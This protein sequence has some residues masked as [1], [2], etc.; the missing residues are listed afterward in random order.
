[1]LA[2]SVRYAAIDGR[3]EDL[4][5]NTDAALVPLV[6]ENWKKIFTW[7]WQGTMP[8]SERAALKE[9]VIPRA[10]AGAQSS[11]L[12][13]TRPRGSVED[14]PRCRVSMYWGQTIWRAATL[15]AR[16]DTLN[17]RASMVSAR[18]AGICAR[19]CVRITR[20]PRL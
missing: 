16:I 8:D 4:E 20:K 1:M 3:K 9:W 14:S 18:Q 6:S 2:Q 13:Y 15:P 10:C 11:I 5:R 17:P 12:E 7:D 19:E